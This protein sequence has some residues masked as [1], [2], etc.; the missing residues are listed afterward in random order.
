M[1]IYVAFAVSLFVCVNFNLSGQTLE[2]QIQ[3]EEVESHVRFLAADELKG[4]KTGEMGNWVAARYIAEQFRKFG[5]SSPMGLAREYMQEIPFVDV[6]PATEATLEIGNHK[7]DLSEGLIVRMANSG[8]MEAELMYLPHAVSDEITDAVRGKIVLTHFGSE[9][10]VDPIAAMTLTAEKRKDL[11]AKGAMGLVEIYTGRHPWAL[12]KRFLGGGGLTVSDE[13]GGAFPTLM[14]QKSLDKVIE[15]LKSGKVVSARFETDGTKGRKMPS[16]NVVGVI[17]GRDAQLKDEYIALTAHFDHIGTRVSPEVP[18]TE[19]DSIYNGARDNAF[20]VSALLSAA[21]TLAEDPPQRSVILIAFTGE[22]I[23]LLGSKYFVGNPI[24]PLKQI[25][26]N[27]NTDG[28]GHS[29]STIVSVM[30][31]DRVGAREEIDLAC[32]TF[33]LGT[34]ADPAPEQ[35]LFDRSDNV[36]FAAAGIPAPTFSPGFRTFD[37]AIMRHYHQPSDEVETLDLEYVLTFCKAYAY[38]ARLIANKKQRPSWPKGDKYRP[39]F[40]QLYGL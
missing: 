39:A 4:R 5:V 38:C 12:M 13:A 28:A 18:A 31:L 21:R 14:I 17:E 19:F 33:G 9:D 6:T 20:G 26:F 29:D 15:N 8:T 3:L 25:V 22:E 36:S 16:A 27:L 40:D 30:G 24:V 11:A 1:R 10:I 37:A 32:K 2:Q 34:F 35:N 23:G 7:I